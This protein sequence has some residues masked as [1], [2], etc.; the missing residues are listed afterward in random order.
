MQTIGRSSRTE[1]P[2]VSLKHEVVLDPSIRRTDARNI[3][4]SDASR[5]LLTG[6]TGFLEA[7]LL[8]DL[9]QQTDARFIVWCRHAPVAHTLEFRFYQYSILCGPFNLYT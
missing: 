5:V 1:H 2:V 3:E 6:A 9:L 8:T 4:H 7:F